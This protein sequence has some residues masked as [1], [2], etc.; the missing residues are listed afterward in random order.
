MNPDLFTITCGYC[1]H[2]AELGLFCTTPIGGPLPPSHYQ[3]PQCK[4][5][6][7]VVKTPITITPWGS[8]ISQ[9]NLIK[10]T[11]ASL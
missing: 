10:P 4:R 6:W 3:C 2:N 5:A 11:D 1:G 7:A 8:V 9:P